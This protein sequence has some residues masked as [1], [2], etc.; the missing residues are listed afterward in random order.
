MNEWMSVGLWQIGLS[1]EFGMSK[2]MDS[3]QLDYEFTI[4][5]MSYRSKECHHNGNRNIGE[6]S[7]K[8]CTAAFF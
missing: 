7:L 3:I 2:W 8:K 4:I 1:I 5:W 6:C